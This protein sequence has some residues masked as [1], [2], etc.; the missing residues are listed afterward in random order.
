[1]AGLLLYLGPRLVYQARLLI[2]NIPGYV[3]QFVDQA[4]IDVDTLS[5]Q[6][7][8][9]VTGAAPP[10]P[11]SPPIAQLGLGR[12]P[13][14][15]EAVQLVEQRLN[16]RH[17]EPAV[18]EILRNGPARFDSLAKAGS[19]S[20]G[21]G[22]SPSHIDLRAITTTVLDWLDVGYEVVASTIGFATYISAAAVIL[23]EASVDI[24]NLAVSNAGEFV[25]ETPCV[26]QSICI[27][28]ILKNTI[29]EDSPP[30]VFLAAQSCA[31]QQKGVGVV[32]LVEFVLATD[33]LPG[34]RYRSS[35]SLVFV[36]LCP[37]L[38]GG[39]PTVSAAHGTSPSHASER[40]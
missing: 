26:V 25:Q 7:K 18:P 20:D 13:T 5:L 36:Q 22:W 40:M 6:L 9:M 34:S 3:N 27:D 10:R 39:L 14:P 32:V 37:L 2:A 33:D 1:V 11:A 4:N 28:N 17:I 31:V 23:A 12:W 15:E 35:A 38:L 29:D 30:V 8:Q 19:T 24:R 16:P 21:P